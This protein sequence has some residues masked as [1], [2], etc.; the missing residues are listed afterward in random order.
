MSFFFRS[1]SRSLV[2]SC[3]STIVQILL[4]RL[5]GT[6]FF[7]WTRWQDVKGRYW[8]VCWFIEYVRGDCHLLQGV[9]SEE[10]CF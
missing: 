3:S 9:G 5:K 2:V 8:N 4:A 10:R 7:V 1:F 6:F